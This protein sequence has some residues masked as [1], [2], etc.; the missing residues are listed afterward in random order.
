MKRNK[1]LNEATRF[2][3]STQKIIP[4]EPAVAQPTKENP[5][6]KTFGG[7]TKQPQNHNNRVTTAYELRDTQQLHSYVKNLIDIIGRTA[8]TKAEPALCHKPSFDFSLRC[9]DEV[10]RIS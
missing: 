9:L 10:P 6:R 7:S 5:L 1:A 3:C 8:A 4:T 2:V